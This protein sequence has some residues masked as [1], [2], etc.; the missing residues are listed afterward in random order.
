VT[1]RLPDGTWVVAWVA[2]SGGPVTLRVAPVGAGG[3]LGRATDVATGGRIDGVRAAS[4]GKG[5]DLWWYES[6]SLVRIAEV[7]LPASN[8]ANMGRP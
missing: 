1:A 5:V 3:V 4:T 8:S 7:E 2:S 6:D